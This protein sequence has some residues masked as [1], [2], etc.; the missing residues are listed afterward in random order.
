MYKLVIVLHE[1]LVSCCVLRMINT[2]TDNG[3]ILHGISWDSRQDGMP[4]VVV[5][6][7]FDASSAA[8]WSCVTAKMIVLAAIAYQ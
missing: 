8:V 1:H 6:H 7:T 4:L 3:P 5:L 2:C